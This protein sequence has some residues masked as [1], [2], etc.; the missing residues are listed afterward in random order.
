MDLV[1]R[2]P[3]RVADLETSLD[4]WLDSFEHATASGSVSM[5]T[6]TKARLEELGY[7]Q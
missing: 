2:R 4:D 5:S 1:G 7:L 6:A 3:E